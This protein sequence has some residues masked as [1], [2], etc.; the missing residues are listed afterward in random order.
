MQSSRLCSAPLV[1]AISMKHRAIAGDVVHTMQGA[2]HNSG[3]RGTH[4]AGSSTQQR[5]TWYTLCREQ[6]TTAGDVVHTMHG[7]VH[8]SGRRG[9]DYAGSSTHQRDERYTLC[10]EQYP[11]ARHA[12]RTV[13]AAR[14][15]STA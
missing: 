6:Y 5:E 9:T 11:P 15:R 8:T 1:P 4:Y 10:T 2:V 13:H 3:R 7:A 14:A 12:V